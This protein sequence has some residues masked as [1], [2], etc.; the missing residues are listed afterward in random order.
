MAVRNRTTGLI[1]NQ[2][3]GSKGGRFDRATNQSGAPLPPQSVS[4]AAAP[5]DKA[6]HFKIL[7][8]TAVLPLFRRVF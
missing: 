8:F 4:A 2:A 5:S 6:M 1:A 3:L 7:T